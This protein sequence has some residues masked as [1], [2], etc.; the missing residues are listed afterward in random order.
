MENQWE[1][2]DEIVNI[3]KNP[4][5]DL[6]EN[7]VWRSSRLAGSGIDFSRLKKWAF[8]VNYRTTVTEMDSIRTYLNAFFKLSITWHCLMR[9]LLR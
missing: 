5:Y 9:L 8:T 4:I 2:I 6:K 1:K 3:L 7:V